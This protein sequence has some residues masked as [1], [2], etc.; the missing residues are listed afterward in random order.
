M[1]AIRRSSRGLVVSLM[2]L[3]AS[4]AGGLATAQSAQEEAQAERDNPPTTL[5]FE[6]TVRSAPPGF[7]PETDRRPSHP[8]RRRPRQATRFAMRSAPIFARAC[9]RT[10]LR[11]S[12]P[13]RGKEA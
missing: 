9:L 2:A 12:A 13:A 11:H 8:R 5:P 6:P 10:V 7:S 3:A 1:T 4:S